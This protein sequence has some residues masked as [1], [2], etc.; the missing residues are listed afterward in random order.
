[1]PLHVAVAPDGL[2]L[3][4]SGGKSNAQVAI[5]VD[6]PAFMRAFVERLTR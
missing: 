5:K 6:S 4:V 2:T 3:P 1:M